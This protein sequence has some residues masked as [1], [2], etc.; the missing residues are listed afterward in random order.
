MDDKK[1]IEIEFVALKKNYLNLNQDLDQERA[2]NDNIGMELVNLVNENK[3][4]QTT[5]DKGKSLEGDQ[6]LSLDK[7]NQ[8]TVKELQDTKDA[9]SSAKA[10][11]EKL[12]TE[13]LKLQV[14]GQ[15]SLQENE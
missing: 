4:M 5:Q 8:A 1:E 9:L 10:E 7:R 15:R 11:I 14:E 3:A 2:K 12:K 6:T 13:I